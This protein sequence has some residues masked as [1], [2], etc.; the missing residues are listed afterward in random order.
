[1]RA[2]ELRH[3]GFNP[4]YLRYAVSHGFIRRVGHGL[5]SSFEPDAGDQHSFA[6]VAKR[7]PSALICLLSAMRFHELGTQNPTMI[8]VALPERAWKPKFDFVKA[9]VVR[10]SEAS[11]THGVETHEVEGV[12][13][14]VTSVAK[15]VADLFKYRNKIGVDV[16]TEALREAWRS[17]R[18]TMSDLVACAKIDRVERVM[19][20]Y[21]ESLS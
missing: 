2:A 1:M 16:A 10:F 8:W 13:V 18:C 14:R 7:H 21:L 19:R 5:Y 3:A 6:L 20:P 17:R 11:F 15:T 9:R 12:P 4:E